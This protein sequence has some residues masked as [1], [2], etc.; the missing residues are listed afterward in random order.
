MHQAAHASA[1]P[2]LVGQSSFILQAHDKVRQVRN[3]NSTVTVIGPSGGGK[4]V[5]V[6]LLHFLSDTRGSGPFVPVDCGALPPSLVESELFGHEEGAFTGALK[7]HIGFLEQA[8]GGDLFL[9]EF[10]NLAEAV[11]IKLLRV[12]QERRL[13]RVGGSE[14]IPVDFRLLLAM[15]KTPREHCLLGQLREDLMHRVSV[16]TISLPPLRE[17]REDIPLLLEF[18]SRKHA[19]ATG[20]PLLEFSKETRAAFLRYP[21]PGNVRELGNEIENL[22]AVYPASL[23]EPVHLNPEIRKA[24][25]TTRRGRPPRDREVDQRRAQKAVEMTHGDAHA[26]ARLLGVSLATFYNWMNGV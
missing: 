2:E 21:W 20:R 24:A 16:V 15:Q 9:D 4:E 6:R 12:L 5:V 1:P 18:W 25:E 22:Y 17:R 23:I 8:N 11:Q 13:R 3:T 10:P 19:A 26:A 14:L 7:R